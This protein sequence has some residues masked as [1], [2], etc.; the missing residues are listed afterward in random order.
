MEDFLVKAPDLNAVFCENDEMALGALQAIKADQKLDQIMVV[1]FD[2]N[3]DALESIKKG[4]LAATVAQDPELMG[5]MAIVNA[6]QVFAG[7]LDINARQDIYVPIKL[8]T[9]KDVKGE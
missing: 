1:G 3:P 8:I 4:E 2:G 9:P 6:Y 7:T 5:R